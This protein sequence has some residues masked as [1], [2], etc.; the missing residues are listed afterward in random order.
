MERRLQHEAARDAAIAQ[1]ETFTAYE[2][3][4]E[5]VEVFKYL[6]RLLAYD[7]DDGPTI[8]AN[9]RKARKCWARISKVLRAENASPRVSGL[10]YRATVQAVLLFGSETWNL[11]G[12]WL[13][14]LEGFHLWAAWQMAQESEPQRNHDGSWVYPPSA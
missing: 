4:L 13:K 12:T 1:T 2:E 14:K 8:L 11:T 9:L 6:G 10:F 7:D 3:Q 5:R